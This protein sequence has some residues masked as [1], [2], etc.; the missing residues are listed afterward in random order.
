M[1]KNSRS[2]AARVSALE[3]AIANKQSG[4]KAAKPKVTRKTN[5]EAANSHGIFPDTPPIFVVDEADAEAALGIQ[6]KRS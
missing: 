4:E 3:K 5:R 1:A 2:L 6:H